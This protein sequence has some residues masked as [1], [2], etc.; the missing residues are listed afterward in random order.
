MKLLLKKF[1]R[2]IAKVT[3]KAAPPNKGQLQAGAVL[4]AHNAGNQAVNI[5]Q[6]LA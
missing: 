6:D 1:K 4:A 3:A 2:I 5:S